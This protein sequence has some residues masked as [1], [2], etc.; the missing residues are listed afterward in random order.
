MATYRYEQSTIDGV[1]V[2]EVWGL[3]ATKNGGDPVREWTERHAAFAKASGH[4]HQRV[5][6]DDSQSGHLLHEA[7]REVPADEGEPRWEASR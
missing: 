2:S 1:L 3:R 5:T 4:V 6:V 7:W